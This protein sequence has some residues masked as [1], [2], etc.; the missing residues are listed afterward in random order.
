MLQVRDCG[1]TH[2]PNPPPSPPLPPAPPPGPW[3]PRWTATVPKEGTNSTSKE[4]YSMLR[5]AHKIARLC[6]CETLQ[7]IG[8]TTLIVVNVSPRECMELPNRCNETSLRRYCHQDTQI[9]PVEPVLL[10]RGGSVCASN[11]QHNTAYAIMQHKAQISS[12]DGTRYVW[13]FAACAGCRSAQLRVLCKR[14][15]RNVQPRPND[16]MVCKTSWYS[17]A[18]YCSSLCSCGSNVDLP[19]TKTYDLCTCSLTE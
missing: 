9:T 12:A 15:I 19:C 13:T 4:L 1:S 5:E 6:G 7:H 10:I 14:K 16:F 17:V 2:P 18:P 8:V 11:M 3:T